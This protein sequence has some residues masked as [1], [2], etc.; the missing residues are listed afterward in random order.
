LVWGV[1]T[2]VLHGQKWEI[3]IR[4]AKSEEPALVRVEKKV[5]IPWIAGGHQCSFFSS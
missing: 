4:Q 2:L 3:K 1:P 5:V